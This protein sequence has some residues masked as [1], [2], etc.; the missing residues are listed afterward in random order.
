MYPYKSRFRTLLAE[1][2]AHNAVFSVCLFLLFI[3]FHFDKQLGC[4]VRRG[5]LVGQLHRLGRP[6]VGTVLIMHRPLG[7]ADAGVV[8]EYLEAQRLPASPMLREKW[9]F[10]LSMYLRN[11]VRNLSLFPAAGSTPS[12]VCLGLPI[13]LFDAGGERIF[14]PVT[15]VHQAL[16]NKP[17]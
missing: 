5:V 11:V 7:V 17:F 15:R 2:R 9:W 6:V 16:D 3:L 12:A 1:V 13:F 4:M 10:V 8:Q 14:V